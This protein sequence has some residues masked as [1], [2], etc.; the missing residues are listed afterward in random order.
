MIVSKSY[1]KVY[2]LE[3]LGLPDYVFNQLISIDN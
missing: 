1:I 2:I 3:N